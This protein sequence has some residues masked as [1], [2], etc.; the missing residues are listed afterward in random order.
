V[1]FFIL[2]IELEYYSNNVDS[3]ELASIGNLHD[4][5]NALDLKGIRALVQD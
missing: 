3:I 2:N 4:L 5:A 1:A